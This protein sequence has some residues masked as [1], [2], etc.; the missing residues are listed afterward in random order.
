MTSL[1]YGLAG[2]VKNAS[3]LFMGAVLLVLVIA[4]T[5]VANLLMARTTD[6]AG[7]CRYAPRFEQAA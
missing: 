3:L 5:N 1:Q 4:C 6:R 2:P 7:S